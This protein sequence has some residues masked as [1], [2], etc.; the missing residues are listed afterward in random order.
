MTPIRQPNRSLSRDRRFGPSRL[1][2]SKSSLPAWIVASW[3][4]NSPNIPSTVALLPEPD[5]PTS[6]T[7]SPAATS[8]VI[9][10]TACNGPALV[11]KVTL[12]PSTS[13]TRSVS[14]SGDW[15]AALIAAS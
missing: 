3:V 8:K 6:P 13:R 7:V 12:S 14:R 2:D 9:P 5:S 10:R 4:W 1:T 15:V 11:R